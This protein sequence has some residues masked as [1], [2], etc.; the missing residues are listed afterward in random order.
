[1]VKSYC[2]RPT[3]LYWVKV[4]GVPGHKY[5]GSDVAPS[6]FIPLEST[7]GGLQMGAMAKSAGLVSRDPIHASPGTPVFG[8]GCDAEHGLSGQRALIYVSLVG[9]GQTCRQFRKIH[10]GTNLSGASKCRNRDGK[11]LR[12]QWNAP[13]IAGPHARKRDCEMKR[14]RR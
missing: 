1:M 12:W 3:R 9:A 11:I 2:V 5:R 7:I 6:T 10:D 4:T 8:S 13:R 14:D